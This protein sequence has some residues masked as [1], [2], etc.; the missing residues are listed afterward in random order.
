M[1][2]CKHRWVEKTGRGVTYVVCSTCREIS[3]GLSAVLERD[4]ARA[5]VRR[6]RR[7]AKRAVTLPRGVSAKVLRHAGDALDRTARHMQ[8]HSPDTEHKQWNTLAHWLWELSA[9]LTMPTPK[10]TE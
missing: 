8:Q 3:H 10:E 5:E 1:S 2:A 9:A 6:L 7:E 4:Q